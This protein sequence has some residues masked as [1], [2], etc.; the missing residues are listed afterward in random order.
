MLTE[1]LMPARAI[2]SA[3]V[4]FGMVSIP[5]KLYTATESSAGISFNW[6][7]KK[8]GS[9]MKQQYFCPQDSEVVTRDEMV[10]GYEFAKDRYVTFTPD[11]LKAIEEEATQTIEITEFVPIEKV[12]PI[13][14][15]RP[16]YVGPDKGGDKAYRLLARAMQETGRAALGRYAARGKQ[17]LV[18]LRPI[19]DRLVMQQL[20]YADEIRSRDEV[21]AP[22]GDVKDAELRLAVQ[23]IGQISAEEFRPQDYKDEVRTRVRDLIQK[24]VEG[25]EISAAPPEAKQGAQI[26]DLMEALKAS[27]GAKRAT[28]ERNETSGEPKPVAFAADQKRKPAR[29]APRAVSTRKAGREKKSSEA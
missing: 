4:S 29:R 13:Y 23:L 19:G 22:E 16:Y 12:D 9:R 20:L 3:T 1:N 2:G 27:L 25:E 21:P 5:I 18:M 8:C 15:D 24:K 6:L 7:H 28:R 14:Y 11:E 26:I 17:Y 10:K